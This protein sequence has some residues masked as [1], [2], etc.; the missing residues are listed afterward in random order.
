MFAGA[1]RLSYNLALEQ[2]RD[3]WRAYFRQT[4]RHITAASQSRELTE[5]RRQYDW[6]AAVPRECMERALRDLEGAYRAFFAGRKGY[7]TPKRKGIRDSIHFQGRTV[8]AGGYTKRWG[9]VRLFGLG[10][11]SYRD[12]RP[13]EGKIRNVTVSRDAVGWHIVFAC[14]IER[15]I[16]E[17]KMASVGI[18]RGVANTLALST[19]EMLSL[20]DMSAIDRQYARAQRS[21][22]RRKRGS[23]R[24]LRQL[25]KCAKI[26]ARRARIRKNWQHQASTAISRRFSYVALEN[27]RVQ[28]MTAKGRGK[29]GL[30]RVILNQGWYAFETMLAY[31]LD[32]RGGSLHKVPAAYTSQTCSRCGTVDRESRESQAVFSCRHCGSSMHA[33]TNAAINIIR[34]SASDLRVE[35]AARCPSKREPNMVIH[36]GH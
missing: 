25:R 11:I 15:A 20:P 8:R 36:V 16:P 12:T 7:P 32:E 10:N 13:I 23:G 4:G 17:A 18:D 26:S 2:R 1:V 34:R 27:L 14:E 31:K 6:M 28:G 19:G 21:L 30:N 29:S 35:G 24:R 9:W 5:L 22:T 33:D 3:H